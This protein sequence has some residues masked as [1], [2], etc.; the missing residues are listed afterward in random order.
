MGVPWE[1]IAPK[2]WTVMS[3]LPYRPALA[4]AQQAAVGGVAW[5]EPTLVLTG[6]LV[7]TVGAAVWQVRK[8]G[9]L[10]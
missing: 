3:F 7:L 5:V 1:I 2:V 8:R 10:R 6:W 9:F 4:L